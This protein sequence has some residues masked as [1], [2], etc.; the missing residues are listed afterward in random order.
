MHNLCTDQIGILFEEGCA[1]K[2]MQKY[3]KILPV[4]LCKK[5][6]TTIF[7]VTRKEI[8]ELECLYGTLAVY[9]LSSVL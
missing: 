5:T 2:P 8:G 4:C 9:E 3:K 1:D 7:I 6:E